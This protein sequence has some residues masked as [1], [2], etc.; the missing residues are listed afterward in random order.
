MPAAVQTSTAII[1]SRRNSGERDIFIDAYTKD[2]GYVRLLAR[3]AKDIKSKFSSQL[4]E[5]A[6]GE[7]CWTK[8]KRYDILVN[9]DTR[10]VFVMD[11]ENLQNVRLSLDFLCRMTKIGEKDERIFAATFAFLQTPYN[12]LDFIINILSLLGWSYSG[13]HNKTELGKFV[14][15]HTGEVVPYLK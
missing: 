12:W 7:I 10:Y 2:F 5:G 4:L 6:V 3:G 14:G 11:F 13:T 8:G 9:A 1:L 15:F